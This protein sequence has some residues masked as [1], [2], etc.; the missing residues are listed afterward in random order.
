MALSRR[1]V[2]AGLGAAVAA[3]AFKVAKVTLEYDGL[4]GNPD[5]TGEMFVDA[6]YNELKS[7]PRATR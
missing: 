5:Y 6:I 3:P 2:V 7:T 4:Y 1:T